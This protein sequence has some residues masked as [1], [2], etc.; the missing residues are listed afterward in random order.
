MPCSP[1][2]N[3]AFPIP[4]AASPSASPP[5][6]SASA[7]TCALAGYQLLAAAANTR[8]A[9]A[10]R[11]PVAQPTGIAR[12]QRAQ[13]RQNLQP[14]NRQRQPHRRPHRPDLRR[15]PHPREHR[16]PERRR[17]TGLPNLPLHRAHR[18]LGNR[19]LAH[20]LPP[21]R[22]AAGHPG[23]SHRRRPRGRPDSP[24]SATRPARSTSSTCS[25]PSARC[26]AWRTACFTTRADRT[27]AYIQ[28]YKALGG[29]WSAGS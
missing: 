6:P 12:P 18:A 8:A 28:L 5:T 23:K 24:T 11:Y 20:R 4:P 17:G 2:A 26:S 7:R 22:R 21:H 16:G 1:P 27:T 29:G 10:E 9:D 15:R 19:E 14:G 3:K 25:T 13:R